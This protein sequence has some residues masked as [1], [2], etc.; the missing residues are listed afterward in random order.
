[1]SKGEAAMINKEKDESSFEIR[2]EKYDDGDDDRSPK[3][4]GEP[5]A[6]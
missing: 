2:H 6:C 5:S 1:M 4:E 3:M